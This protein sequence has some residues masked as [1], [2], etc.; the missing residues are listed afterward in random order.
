[1]KRF[2]VATT[3][4]SGGVELH[5]M[6]EWLRQHPGEIPAGLDATLS[7]SHQPRNGLKKKAGPTRKPS[8]KFGC[9]SGCGPDE[10]RRRTL[11]K[12]QETGPSAWNISCGTSSPRAFLSMDA[13]C[14]CMWTPRG[15][16]ASSSGQQWGPSTSWRRTSRRVHSSCSN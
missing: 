11:P 5:P 12:V 14:G 3:T 15:R 2:L 6:K 1:M 9:A 8:P 16:T 13:T 10:H 4:E 7:T